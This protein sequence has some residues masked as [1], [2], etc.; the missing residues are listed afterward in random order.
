MAITTTFSEGIFYETS[1]KELV[2]DIYIERCHTEEKGACIFNIFKEFLA[3]KFWYYFQYMSYPNISNS[4][5]VQST[6]NNSWRN[7]KK[8]RQIHNDRDLTLPSQQLKEV[9]KSVRTHKTQTPWINMIWFVF[10]RHTPTT[11]YTFFTS[12]YEIFSKTDYTL[13]HKVSLNKLKRIK[14]YW[15]QTE[16]TP[17]S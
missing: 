7:W 1:H 6:W 12:T 9:T 2:K 14:K 10:M 5:E 16:Y 3:V 15:N 17:R 4:L 13:N 8:N 11:E